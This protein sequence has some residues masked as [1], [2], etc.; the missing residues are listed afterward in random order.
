MYTLYIYT[1]TIYLYVYIIHVPIPP[2]IYSH[3]DKS[4]GLS[5]QS[6]MLSGTP[7]RGGEIPLLD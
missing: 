4:A 1:Y 6:R 7:S 3:A 2:I 5:R